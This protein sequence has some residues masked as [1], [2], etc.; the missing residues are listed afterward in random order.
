[1][2]PSTMQL[3][4]QFIS[5]HGFPIVVSAALFWYIVVEGRANRKVIEELKD[6]LT[7][8]TKVMTA[9]TDLIKEVTRNG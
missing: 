7:E 6:V 4:G 9:F 5:Q 2:E 1:M 3:I 8:N